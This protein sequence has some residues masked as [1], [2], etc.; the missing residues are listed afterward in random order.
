[1]IKNKEIYLN[2]EEAVAF[3]SI[4]SSLAVLFFTALFIISFTINPWFLLGVII[5]VVF[6][7]LTSLLCN[8]FKFK[9]LIINRDKKTNE[10]QKRRKTNKRKR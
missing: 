2:E 7:N 4:T 9:D 3:G 8:Y 1:M 6:Y 5:M 10:K